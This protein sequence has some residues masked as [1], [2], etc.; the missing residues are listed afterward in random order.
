M[1]GVAPEGAP[2]LL[3]FLGGRFLAGGCPARRRAALGAALA[4][5]TPGLLPGGAATAP[6]SSSGPPTVRFVMTQTLV[7][8]AEAGGEAA[9]YVLSPTSV[10]PGDLLR[11]EITVTNVSGAALRGVLVA[12]PV[13]G[14]TAYVGGATPAAAGWTL[15]FSD[16][17]GRTYAAR[18]GRSVSSTENGRAVSWQVAAPPETYTH[19]RW[20]VATLR[21][22]ETLKFSF[23][24]RVRVA[25]AQGGG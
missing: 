16:D 21:A 4:L 19:V 9:S 12:V 6:A 24:V 8:P 5:L 22:G 20:T 2:N 15:Q 23:R 18:P 7:R 3:R 13:P 25:G 1:F 10:V 11:E 17:R 14:G